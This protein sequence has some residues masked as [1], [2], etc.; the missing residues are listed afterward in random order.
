MRSIIKILGIWS[1]I[2]RQFKQIQINLAAQLDS[3]SAN[4]HSEQ[5]VS[6]NSSDRFGEELQR[7]E[8]NIRNT[9]DLKYFESVL[10]FDQ[11]N[12]Y[13]WDK[14]VDSCSSVQRKRPKIRRLVFNRNIGLRKNLDIDFLGRPQKESTGNRIFESALKKSN[15]ESMNSGWSIVSILLKLTL[16]STVIFVLIVSKLTCL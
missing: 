9:F 8:A 6:E 10:S 14:L 7:S 3:A 16:K 1:S 15:D 12:E 4:T 2:S 11:L 13:K 5:T